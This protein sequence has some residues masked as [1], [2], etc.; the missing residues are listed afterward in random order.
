MLKILGSTLK[1][2]KDLYNLLT[3]RRGEERNDKQK[4]HGQFKTMLV[5]FPG[6]QW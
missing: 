6:A 5:G 1:E 3:I 2:Q 4:N